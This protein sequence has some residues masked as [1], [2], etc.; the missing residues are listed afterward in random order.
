VFRI[1]TVVTFVV[2]FGVMVGC[3]ADSGPDNPAG[4]DWV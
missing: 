2:T 4:K 3:R 1:P